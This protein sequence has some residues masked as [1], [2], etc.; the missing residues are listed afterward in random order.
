MTTGDV[1]SKIIGMGLLTVDEVATCYRV[2]EENEEV[3]FELDQVLSNVI[4][5][6]RYSL[7]RKP[8]D[9]LLN[10][11]ISI[12]CLTGKIVIVRVCLQLDTIATIKARIQ[13]QEGIHHDQQDLIFEGKRLEDCRTLTGS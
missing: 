2:T 11:T 5:G 4:D 10:E 12:K 1:V 13:N 3:T 9:P 6:A 8:V 7:Q